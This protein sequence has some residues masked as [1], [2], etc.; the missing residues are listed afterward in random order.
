MINKEQLLG[1]VLGISLTFPALAQTDWDYP[2]DIPVIEPVAVGLAGEKPADIVRYLMIRGAGQ[3]GISPDGKMIAFSYR[4]TGE[5]QVW[6]VDAAGGWPRQL[7]FGT[8]IR[9][10]SW[11]PD[12]ENLLVTRDADGNEREGYYL[13]SVDGTRERQL[14][15]LSDAFR[16]FGMF[17]RN[18]SQFLFSST[19]RNGRDFDIYVTDVAS[20]ETSMVFEGTFGFFPRA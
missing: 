17:S 18:G 16:Q 3:A 1:T 7:T 10:F 8:G 13:L 14:L 5:P 12:G 15:P 19:E 2:D 20:G 4:V 11:S 9:T 6:V